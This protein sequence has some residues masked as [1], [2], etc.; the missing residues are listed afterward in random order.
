M[1]YWS[2]SPWP[3]HSRHATC[4]AKDCSININCHHILKV[5]SDVFELARIQKG[6][7]EGVEQLLNRQLERLKAGVM[8]TVEEQLKVIL[9]WGLI[10]SIQYSGGSS[11]WGWRMQGLNG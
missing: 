7:V 10:G 9:V 3:R 6:L 1:I 8:M 11:L 2:I 4:E 5:K